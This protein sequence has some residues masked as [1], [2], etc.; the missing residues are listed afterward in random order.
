MMTFHQDKNILVIGSENHSGG[1]EKSTRGR[2]VTVI[3]C[4]SCARQQFD[5]IKTVEEVE[6]RLEHITDSITVSLIG[7]VVNGPGEAKETD[8]GLTGGG[9]GTHQIYV[10]GITDHIIRNENVADY[11]VNFVQKEIDQR[12]KIY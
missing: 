4:P 6:Q 2:G 12:K 8:I 3:S 10:N 11:I 5:V 9:K 7:C 1:L